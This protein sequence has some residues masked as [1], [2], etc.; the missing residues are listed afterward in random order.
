M[1]PA[2]EGR[3]KK[4]GVEIKAEIGGS[5]LGQNKMGK[6]EERRAKEKKNYFHRIWCLITVAWDGLK[7][8][9]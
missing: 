6:R 7:I 4:R 2:A 1:L 5:K 9:L 3:G 8:R